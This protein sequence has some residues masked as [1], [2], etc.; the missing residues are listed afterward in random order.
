M[1]ETMKL[2]EKLITALDANHGYIKLMAD[3]YVQTAEDATN[4]C[5]SSQETWAA[6]LFATAPYWIICAPENPEPIVTVRDLAEFLEKYEI[7]S[8]AIDL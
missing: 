1:N 6:P 7:V 2:A 5:D 8:T 3:V 4:D